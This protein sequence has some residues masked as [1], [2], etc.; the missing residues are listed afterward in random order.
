MSKR[1]AEEMAAQTQQL[2]KRSKSEIPEKSTEILINSHDDYLES[3]FKWLNLKDLLKMARVS[4]RFKPLISSIIAR[5]YAKD[6]LK[7]TLCEYDTTVKDSA[8]LVLREMSLIVTF[9]RCL[10]SSISKL[11]V[12]FDE[13]KSPQCLAIEES[14][15]KFCDGLK[16]LKLVDC[17]KGA[18]E[19][20]E[21]PFEQMEVFRFS[22]GHLGQTIS[23]F[24]KWFPKL[25]SVSIS[26]ATVANKYCIE[27]TMPLLEHLNVKI[28]SAS[29]KFSQSNIDEAIRS[30][31]Q[32]RSYNVNNGKNRVLF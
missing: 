30:N 7:I 21:K 20:I 6:L 24:N 29:K 1:A 32:L 19:S 26:H 10:G 2:I 18:F 5:Q 12:R 9:L 11:L 17:R 8:V 31:P 23:Q 28:G 27:E 15:L 14:I 16:E 25:R 4:N 22:G 13:K 3:I